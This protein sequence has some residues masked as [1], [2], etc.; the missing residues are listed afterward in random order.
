MDPEDGVGVPPSDVSSQAVD[1]PR[2]CVQR[3][4]GLALPPAGW[5]WDHRAEGR[6]CWAERKRREW[7]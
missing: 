6:V 4:G 5:A 3:R 2:A 1:F 7:L